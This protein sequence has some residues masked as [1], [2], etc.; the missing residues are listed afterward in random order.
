[1][2]IVGQIEKSLAELKFPDGRNETFRF[3]V[4]DKLMA[5][6]QPSAGLNRYFVWDPQTARIV[7][8]ADWRYEIKPS[9]V[10][11]NSAEIRRTNSAGKTQYWFSEPGMGRETF[12]D[13][14]GTTTTTLIFVSGDGVR[15]L[16]RKVIVS[17][18]GKSAQAFAASYGPD[19]RLLR[20]KDE[21]GIEATYNYDA[22]GHQ[23][24]RV[25]DGKPVWTKSY[26]GNGRIASLEVPNEKTVTV[27]Y[28][29][30]GESVVTMQEGGRK[31]VQ[32]YDAEGNIIKRSVR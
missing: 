15:G 32:A 13:L 17:K 9:S 8:E 11:Q 10:P 28:Q 2:R 18:D 4:D 29:K 16:L 24:Q 3:G 21:A 23:T 22:Q 30:G 25:I 7:R 27:Q 12:E 5:T 26:D 6:L 20:W 19:G 14:D 31:W 1:V